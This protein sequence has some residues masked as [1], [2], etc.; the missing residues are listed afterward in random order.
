[1]RSEGSC[2]LGIP[3]GARAF[4]SAHVRRINVWKQNNR[5]A[6]DAIK[7]RKKVENAALW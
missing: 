7:E 4:N 1:M 6:E 2:L 5:E 3:G